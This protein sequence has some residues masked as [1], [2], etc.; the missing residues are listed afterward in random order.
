MKVTSAVLRSALAV[1]TAT[2]VVATLQA[3]AEVRPLPRIVEKNGRFALFVD[4]APFL[5]MGIEDLTMGDWPP[6]PTVWPAL[7]YMHVNTVE[8]PVYWE[9][10]EP[11]PG[12]FDY[13]VIDRLLAAA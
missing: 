3:Q 10:F 12:K 9:D 7:Q 5:I 6:R 1:L 8:I 2:L 11:Q 4:G 13:A